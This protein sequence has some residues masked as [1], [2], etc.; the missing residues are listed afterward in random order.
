MVTDVLCTLRRVGRYVQVSTGLES[1]R[2]VG[3]FNGTEETTDEKS[4]RQNVKTHIYV[5]KV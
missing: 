2:E 4:L 3:V 1:Y 5:D